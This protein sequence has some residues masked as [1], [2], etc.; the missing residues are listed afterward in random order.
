MIVTK[1]NINKVPKE[2]QD[3]LEALLRDLEEI[4]SKLKRE[5]QII[6]IDDDTYDGIDRVSYNG[7]YQL[8]FKDSFDTIGIESTINGLD[9]SMCVL[10]E[11][12]K[13]YSS[14]L[15]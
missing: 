3:L 10:Y 5:I 14:F 9:E 6:W 1:E 7:Y 2:E 8:K 15:I 12:I 11:F 4:N 13:Q